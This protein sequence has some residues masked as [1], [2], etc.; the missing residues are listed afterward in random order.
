[1]L[2]DALNLSPALDVL[3]V[4]AGDGRIL[5]ELARRGHAGRVVGVDPTPGP[6]VQPAHAEALPFPDASFD[7]VLFARVLAH[8]PH[9]ARALAEARR[10]LRPGGV[11]WGAA[12]GPAHLRA[13][14]AALGRPLAPGDTPP[15]SALTLTC[16]LTVSADDARFLLGTYGREAEVSPHLFPVQDA[17]QLLVWPLEP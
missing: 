2:L 6:G 7:V 3:D 15:E 16:P 1:M 11:V 14:W 4:G 10:I 12:H 17:T 9:P 5:R 13:T 8:L